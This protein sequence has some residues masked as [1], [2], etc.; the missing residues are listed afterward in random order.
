MPS[1]PFF[2][3]RPQKHEW[4]GGRYTFPIEVEDGKE[5][6]RPD[7]IIWLEMPDLT[8]VG[9]TLIDPRE[10]ATFTESLNE[11]MLEPIEGPPRR[12]VRIRV[13][14][15]SIANELRRAFR[16]IP[17]IVAPVP[18]LDAAFA[19]LSAMAERVANPSYLEGGAI[20]PTIVGELFE[21]ANL[22]FRAAP[23]RQITEQQIIAVDI[24]AFDIQDAC[25]SVIGAA[26]ET[27]GLLLFR[28]ISDFLVFTMRLAAEEEGHD[29]ALRS[30]TFDRKKDLPPSLTSEIREHRW[31]VAGAKAYP[32]LL[33]LDAAID[34]LP[35]SERDFRI[36]TACTR[37]FLSFFERHADMFEFEDPEPVVFTSGEVTLTAPHLG[38]KPFVDALLDHK[39]D[40]ALDDDEPQIFIDRTVGRND[41]CPC[42][43]GKKYKK[44][45]LDMDSR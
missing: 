15:E 25:M 21:A 28:S 11:A 20:S 14:D 35:A 6:F 10:P 22:L 1:F 13:P 8:L 26:D 5:V 18:E 33:C 43:S 39:S 4:I 23:W 29:V 41:P 37:A 9:S 40:A 24:P 27:L 7:C 32:S 2:R 44:C 12:P 30:L 34:R 45:H 36:M 38:I 19:G 16:G 17:I 42:G 3:E 31:P